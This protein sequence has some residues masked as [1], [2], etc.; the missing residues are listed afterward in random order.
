MRQ[1]VQ[2]T[3]AAYG[4]TAKMSFVTEFIETINAKEPVDA[5]VRA[6][7]A[8]GLKPLVTVRR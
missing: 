1:I 2:G 3:A 5:V 6:A 7:K 8:A 4:F